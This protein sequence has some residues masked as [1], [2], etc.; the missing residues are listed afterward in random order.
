MANV[1]NALTIPATE[2]RSRHPTER[3]VWPL[4]N[5]IRAR[6]RALP[7]AAAMRKSTDELCTTLRAHFCFRLWL[8]R[9]LQHR[10]GLAPDAQ[11]QQD[12]LPIGKFESVVVH[13][14]LVHVLLPENS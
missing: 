4:R 1:R 6:I 11:R 2:W 10:R 8:C 3:P 13:L 12:N 9:K 5:N 14:R 7:P